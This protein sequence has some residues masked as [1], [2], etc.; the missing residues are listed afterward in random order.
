MRLR[1]KKDVDIVP[2]K[3]TS[4]IPT[5]YALREAA[6]AEINSYIKDGI[7]A[8]VKPSEQIVWCAKS[9]F[10]AKQVPT[11][12]STNPNPRLRKNLKPPSVRLVLDNRRQNQFLERD[13][14]PFQSPKELAKSLTPTASVFIVV[15]LWKGYYQCPLHEDDQ[16]DTTF[17]VHEMGCYKF[18]RAP[19]G[20]A[21]S[22][23]HFNKVTE[24]LVEGIQGC[25][26]LIDD[27]L[28]FG[29]SID[30][31]FKSFEELLKRC[32]DKQFTLHP[33]KLQI[34][35]KVAFAGY[36]IT[37]Q[38]ISIDEKKV[39][40]IRNFKRPLS[41]T[42]MKSFIGLAV[43]FKDTCP[44]LMGTLKPLMDTIS[45]KVT[46]AT[47]VKGR[48]IANPKRIIEWSP[49]LEEAF[50]KAKQALT[51]TDGQ[52]LAQYDP[53]LPLIIY[54][55]ASRLNGYGWVSIQIDKDGKKKLI[56]CG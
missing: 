10:V 28:I 53:T 34:G 19:Q 2:F 31:A 32:K 22:G 6:R 56:E 30:E 50:L 37:P 52:I 8:K 14:Y 4:T 18:L 23:D 26:K 46:P 38:G 3:C 7:I 44:N 9:M 48:K 43:Q 15:D 29:Q 51:N 27:I 21:L 45:T 41:V 55:D 17:M 20:C 36:V 16:L 35:R 42:D 5:P 49:M 39:I 13:P 54:T 12:D 40:A 1:Y 24:S 11:P 33:K 25:I 47:D